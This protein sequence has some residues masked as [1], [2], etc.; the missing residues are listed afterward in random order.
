MAKKSFIPPIGKKVT[1]DKYDPEYSDGDKKTAQ[2]E[3]IKL[4]D[5][6]FS[7]QE[8]LYAENRQSL[9]I[10]LQAMDA[11]GKDSTIRH[12]FEGV[13]PQGVQVTSFKQPTELELAHDFLWRIH[14][15]APRKGMIGIFNRSHYED[16]L[17]VR[18]NNIVPEPVWRARYEHINNFERLLSDN[19]TRIVK[20]YLNISKAEQKKQLQERLDDPTKHWK[21]S[22]ADLPVREQWDDYMRA[23]EDVF[24]HCNTEYAPWHIIPSNTRWYRTLTITKIIV[25][26]LEAMNPQ[27]PQPEIGLDAVVIPD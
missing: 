8:R 9:L 6:L 2:T 5:R 16:V 14:H 13:N 18:V 21:F 12:V 20:F 1:L 27:Y 19:G 10:I 24:T 15:H 7:L 26:T 22:S 3:I 23:F 4:Q 11:A 17:V 25:E